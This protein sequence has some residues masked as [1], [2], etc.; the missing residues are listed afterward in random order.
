MLCAWVLAVARALLV[1]L[2]AGVTIAAVLSASH[3]T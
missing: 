3:G 1:L 2:L